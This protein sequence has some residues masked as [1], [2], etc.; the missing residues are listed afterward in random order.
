M[1]QFRAKSFVFV[2]TIQDDS[3]ERRIV[4]WLVINSFVLVFN[5]PLNVCN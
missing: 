4:F 5:G 2:E 3:S 1:K